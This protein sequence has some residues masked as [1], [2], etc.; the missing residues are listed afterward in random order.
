MVSTADLHPYNTEAA[1]QT[2]EILEKQLRAAVSEAGFGDPKL[3]P[4]L[5]SYNWFQ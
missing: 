1:R 2:N 4:S 3:D 5:E